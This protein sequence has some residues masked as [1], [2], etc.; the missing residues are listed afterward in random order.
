MSQTYLTMSDCFTVLIDSGSR[1]ESAYP[2]GITHYLE[3]L[4]FTVS[5]I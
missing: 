1:Y 5:M 2:S 4:A 3:K